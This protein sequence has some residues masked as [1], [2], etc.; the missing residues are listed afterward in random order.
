VGTIEILFL[1]DVILALT[2]LWVAWL[3]LSSP[4]LFR[5]I[6]F[7]IS[8]G[9]LL[10]VVWVRLNAP[11]V[12]LAEAS[13]GAGLTGALLLTSLAKINASNKPPSDTDEKNTNPNSTN[14]TQK[15]DHEDTI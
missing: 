9:L 10:S 5:S 8:F 3:A 4:D 6:V 11:D 2:I 1:F 7:F 13:I 15:K 14:I 12:A